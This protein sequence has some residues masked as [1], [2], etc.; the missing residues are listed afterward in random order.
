MQALTNGKYK[1]CLHRAVV[2]SERARR[3]LV[4]FLCPRED[5]V[6]RPPEDLVDGEQVPRAYPDFTWS[7]FYLFTQK[8]YRADAHTLHNF[9]Q[10]ILSSKPDQLHHV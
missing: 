6:V 5:K 1:S 3:S 8:Y 7:D 10:W 4:F 2:N 9:T